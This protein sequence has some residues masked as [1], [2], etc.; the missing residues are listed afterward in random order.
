VSQEDQP[1]AEMFLEEIS[2]IESAYRTMRQQEIAQRLEEL[3]RTDWQDLATVGREEMLRVR[4]E[5]AV[6]VAGQ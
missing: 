6:G 3:V 5:A 1:D 4:A 2:G